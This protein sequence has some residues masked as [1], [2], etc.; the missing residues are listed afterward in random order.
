M[1][2]FEL[3]DHT[4]DLSFRIEGKSLESLFIKAAKAL[5]KIITDKQ[6]LTKTNELQKELILK[7]PDKEILLIDWLKEIL[8][9]AEAENLILAKIFLLKIQAD[10]LSATVLFHKNN[11][12]LFIDIK[13]IT[14]HDLTI[15]FNNEIWSATITCDL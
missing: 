9:F 10:Q 1:K 14:Y 7:A 12:P 15:C 13:A 4:A 8:F 2:D 3:L 5:T 6:I 11:N